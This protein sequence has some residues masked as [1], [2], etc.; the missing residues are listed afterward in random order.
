[1]FAEQKQSILNSLVL[2]FESKSRV[3]ILIY[4]FY[5]MKNN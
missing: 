5:L 3:K 4:D 1:M 2:N